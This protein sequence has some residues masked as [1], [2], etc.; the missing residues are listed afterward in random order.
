MR[1]PWRIIDGWTFAEFTNEQLLAMIQP[2]L[3]EAQKEDRVIAS[4][5]RSLFYTK[6]GIKIGNNKAYALKSLIELKNTSENP[7]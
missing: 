3:S 2:Y 1:G 7:S 4:K 5:L 6:L